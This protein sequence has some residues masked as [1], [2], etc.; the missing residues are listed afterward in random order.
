MRQACHRLREGS[1]TAAGT[2]G[3]L[4]YGKA[5]AAFWGRARINAILATMV[6]LVTWDVAGVG[7][8][9]ADPGYPTRPITLIVPFAA[10]GPTD[11]VAHIVATRMATALGQQIVIENVIG[12][13]GTTAGTRTM[14]AVPD[15]YV[16]M[17]GHMGT[18]ASAGALYPKLAYD[19]ARDFTPIGLVTRASVFIIA[20]K[21]MPADDLDTFIAYAR[22]HAAELTMAHAGIGSV[23]H[24][25][26]LLLNAA[27]D[28][29]PKLAA[30]QGSGPAMA[31]LV[32]GKVDY[33][34]DQVM[35]V[36]PQANANLI[37][38]Y[39]VGD[40]T[41]N[42]SLP[43]VPTAREAGVPQF[44][45]SA[46]NALFAP[47]HVAQP[48]VAKLNAALSTALD[49]PAVRDRLLALGSE[50]PGPDSRSPAAL[51]DIVSS[52]VAKWSG[53][54]RNADGVR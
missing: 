53:L 8:A 20:R 29:R 7:H 10:G 18:H 32:V 13:G 42:A 51:A 40:P 43:R 9:R 19:P 48:I 15:G 45:V 54:L 47:R 11:I 17:L 44:H 6:W 12:A 5:N 31:A 46:W 41:R 2:P 33:M 14:R 22:Q 35:A 30:Y 50:I 49:D 37:R 38:T 27:I 4:A 52:E 34:C 25:T 26:C 36:V 3:R 24:V 39:A 1:S 28:I 21:T 16:I 23:S